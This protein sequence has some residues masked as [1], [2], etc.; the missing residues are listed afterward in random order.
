MY[1]PAIT[2]P[3]NKTWEQTNRGNLFGSLYSSRNTD[4][5]E[6]GVMKLSKRMRYVGRENTSGG[7]FDDTLAIV[8]GSFGATKSGGQSSSAYHVVSSDELFLLDE[9]LDGFGQVDNASTPGMSNYSD[10]V[11]WD[12]KLMVTTT[13]NLSQLTGGTWTSSLMSLT[14]SK[15]HPLAV[16]SINNYLLVGNENVLHQ[17]TAGGTN[18][19]P[20]TIPSNYQI[21][22]IRSEN[23]RTYIGTRSLDN[24]D[25]KVF[26]WDESASAATNSYPVDSKWILS[27]EFVN[28]KF[29]IL[30]DDGRIMQF[31]GGG[32]EKVAE[33]PIYESLIGRWGE[34]GYINNVCVQR[35]LRSIG[36]RLHLNVSGESIVGES[37]TNWYT[38]FPSGIW[39]YTEEHGLY[40]RYG[41]SNSQANE[42]F[43]I[44]RLARTGA[45]SPIYNDPVGSGINPADG[46]Y[47]LAGARVN[48]NTSATEFTILCSVTDG[49]NRG[50][51]ETTRIETPDIAQNAMKLWCKYSG[52]DTSD[53]KILFKFRTEERVNLPFSTT[54]N[55]TYTSSTVFTSTDTLWANAI[56][57]D[58]ITVLDGNG[59]GCTAHITIISEASGTY[60]ITL[61]EAITNVSASDTCRMI[62]DNWTKLDETV[63]SSDNKGYKDIPVDQEEQSTWTQFKV[64][65]RGNSTITIED[66]L[67]VNADHVEAT[68]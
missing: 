37:T 62:C 22:W 66:L 12:S 31:N 43:L 11:S 38:N 23:K 5:T 1:N 67:F 40:H 8:F 32:F 48:G 65:K 42:D 20:V 54:G 63:T 9:D 30:T 14:A 64:E 21:Q 19:T 34:N 17:R 53:D 4:L 57:G 41:L 56:V 61:D 2:F 25:A 52:V 60:T 18:S 29:Y 55:S 6:P 3:N 24:T 46:G 15:P 33:F 13:N 28:S 45:I 26:E 59:A 44:Q 16:S 68:S 51:M 10:G 58:E 27:G 7:D 39:V 35:G 47:L 50:S 49:L 36:G